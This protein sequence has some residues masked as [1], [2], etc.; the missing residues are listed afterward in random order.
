MKN[1]KECPKCGNLQSIL[2]GYWVKCGASFNAD[3]EEGPASRRDAVKQVQERP[4]ISRHISC[5]VIPV[6]LVLFF[7]LIVMPQF[8]AF[9]IRARDSAAITDLRNLRPSL[10]AFY[11]DHEA[12]PESL[13]ELTSFQ[14]STGI[15]L[16]VIKLN[17]NG[18][19][20]MTEHEK[21]N[22]L[23]MMQSGST[24]IQECE[25]EHPNPEWFELFAEGSAGGASGALD[26]YYKSHGRFPDTLDQ[27]QYVPVKNVRMRYLPDPARA[28]YVLSAEHEQGIYR[29]FV[30]G[31]ETI[32]R[33]KTAGSADDRLYE[34]ILWSD[35]G[36]AGAMVNAAKVNKPDELGNT[37][38][39]YSVFTQNT[40]IM[41]MLL[42]QGADVNTKNNNGDSA[43]TMASRGTND[44]TVVSLLEHGALIDSRNNKESTPLTEAVLHGRNEIAKI[45]MKR[46]ANMNSRGKGWTPLFECVDSENA[47][48]LKM[49]VQA[50]ADINGKNNKGAPLLLYAIGNNG[51]QTNKK[52]VLF[53]LERGARVTAKA[54]SGDT[55]LH[56]AADRADNELA[57][58]LL[59]KGADVNARNEGGFT[60]LHLAAAI[61]DNKLVKL[62]LAKGAQVDARDEKGHTPL[63]FAAGR[64]HP[65]AMNTLLKAGAEINAKNKRGETAADMNG[66]TALHNAVKSQNVELLKLLID[67]GM[68]PNPKYK[69]GDTLLMEAAESEAYDIAGILLKHKADINA[70]GQ[71]GRT[72]L[73]HALRINYLEWGGEPHIVKDR[74]MAE[75]LISGGADV[76][77]KY[78]YGTALHLAAW[79][80]DAELV[81]FLLG[82]GAEANVKSDK[83]VKGDGIELDTPLK[84]AKFRKNAE[85]IRI[86]ED[87]GAVE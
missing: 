54:D 12:Y 61:G 36:K 45:L 16:S 66:E 22:R 82:K 84:I 76:N 69:N 38:F 28:F 60:A 57:K 33:T 80:G 55:A 37:P 15:I 56:L 1:M 75:L 42:S 14:T 26:L 58:L 73:L 65:D 72:A 48:A 31:S 52:I 59:S 78:E 13:Q 71:D 68:K 81:N 39:M 23:Y 85:I 3:K 83:K 11:A 20:L 64:D 10:E 53:L 24:E 19:I 62:L 8:N 6:C 29:Y 5:V 67:K 70:K 87:A 79:S 50:G 9:E 17:K 44:K 34:A 35:A 63:M 74:K 77:V 49:L 47:D 2:N 41:E 30:N 21:G 7:R 32:R 86:L 51:R 43:L 40:A 4:W 27:M 46:G 25:R 18:F